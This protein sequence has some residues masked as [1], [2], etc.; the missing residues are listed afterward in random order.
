MFS[1]AILFLF[2]IGDD[3]IKLS[4]KPLHPGSVRVSKIGTITNGDDGFY[5]AIHATLTS[6]GKIVVLD[7]GNNHISI[8]DQIGKRLLTFG[9]SGSGPGELSTPSTVLVARQ[10]IFVPD[11]LKLHIYKMDGSHVLDKN[12]LI[13]GQ[14]ALI[15]QSGDQVYVH[16][17][18]QKNAAY[19]YGKMNLNGDFTNLLKNTRYVNQDND[20][21]QMQTNLIEYIFTESGIY[22]LEKKTYKFFLHDLNFNLQKTYTR[23]FNRVERKANEYGNVVIGRGNLSEKEHKKRVAAANA[24]LRKRMSPYHDDVISFSGFDKNRLYL[25]VRSQ[26]RDEIKI[27]VIENDN[28]IDQ[29][30]VPFEGRFGFATIRNGLML[31]SEKNDEIGPFISIYKLD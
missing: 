1:I 19:L 20:G 18:H 30:S 6:D 15:A 2:F 21:M 16:Q 7:Y 13:E 9:K 12:M 29:I 17:L 8:F 31:V 28:Y 27:D 23:D 4:A 5:N 25:Q 14:Q 10:H 26:E 11:A 3:A 24:A 22:T